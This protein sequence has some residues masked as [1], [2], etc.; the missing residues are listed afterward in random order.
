M[1]ILVSACLLGVN[2]RYD[3]TGEMRESVK[4]LMKD[5][6]LIPVWPETTELLSYI[7]VLV[8]GPFIEEEKDLG[9]KFRGSR[10]Q[11][12]I[13]VR[14]SLKSGKVVLWDESRDFFS[15]GSEA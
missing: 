2:C 12:I 8:D 9:I 4:E 3:G 10:N 13:C 6:Q 14:E 15:K 7:D 11:R 1:K 5:H